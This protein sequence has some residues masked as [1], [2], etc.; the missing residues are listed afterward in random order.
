MIDT[1]IVELRNETKRSG[2]TLYA[3]HVIYII[4][5]VEGKFNSSEGNLM[6]QAI[7][8]KKNDVL[9]KIRMKV[10]FRTIKH[11]R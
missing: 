2:Q 9:S 5:T 10:R 6:P 3:I 8:L 7:V 4:I 1:N 11:L